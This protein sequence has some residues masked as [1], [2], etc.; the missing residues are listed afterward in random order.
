MERIFTI[1]RTTNWVK[2]LPTLISQYNRTPHRT[3]H[4]QAPDDITNDSTEVMVDNIEKSQPA[5]SSG[6]VVGDDVRRRLKKTIFDKGTKQVWTKTIYK[7]NHLNDVTARLNDGSR[8]RFDDLLPI[9]KVRKRSEDAVVEE[10]SRRSVETRH[11]T[12]RKI[13]KDIP[14]KYLDLINQPLDKIG[15]RQRAKRF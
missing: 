15:R 14:K 1:K 12:D 13:K 5:P 2:W 11:K 3:L 10:P 8:V 4:E 6:F 9:E 7:I